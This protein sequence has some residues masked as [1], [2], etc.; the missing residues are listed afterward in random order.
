MASFLDKL[1]VKTAVT[2]RSKR[3]LSCCHITSADFFQFNV[4]YARELVP[5]ESIS[6]GLETF[7][8]MEPLVVP[9]FGRANIKNRAFFVPF[10]TVFPGWNDFI[11][12]SPHIAANASPNSNP[13]VLTSVPILSQY[14]FWNFL[15]FNQFTGSGRTTFANPVSSVPNSTQTLAQW[16]SLHPNGYDYIIQFANGTSDFLGSNGDYQKWK[17]FG[18]YPICL[19]SAGRQVMKLMNSLGYVFSPVISNT[20]TGI[21]GKPLFSALPLLCVAKVYADWFFPNGYS[22]SLF[23]NMFKYDLMDSS[24]ASSVLSLSSDYLRLIFD[25]ILRTSYDPDYFTSAWDQPNAPNASNL[26]GSYYLRD[27]NNTNG[28][29]STSNN[30]SNGTVGYPGGYG[31]TSPTVNST[32]YLSKYALDALAS[33]SDYI[34]RHQLVGARSIDR[35]LARFGIQLSSDKLDRSIYLGEDIV[36]LQIGDV[37]STADTALLGSEGTGMPLGSYAGKGIA[38]GGKTFEH[39]TDEYGMFII[40]SSIIPK[41]GYYQG[42]DR[43]VLHTSALSFWTPEFDSLGSQAISRAEVYEPIDN[44][45]DS[46]QKAFYDTTGSVPYYDTV[47][48]YTP[49]YAEYK[50]AHDRLTGDKRYNSLAVGQDSWHLM[51]V[52]NYR[53]SF[54]V[55]HS[56]NF[57]TGNLN[58]DDFEWSDDYLD[59]FQYDRI[60][61]NVDSGIDHFNIIYQFNVTSWAPM[62][63][64]YDNYEWKDHDKGETVHVDVNGPKMN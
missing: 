41:V 20:P 16:K 47:F 2:T 3:D 45:T 49:R 64:L 38:Y 37:M 8:R 54:D 6:V 53:S 33:L 40:V 22:T 27:I 34:K 1:K 15:L 44:L 18:G 57:V 59:Y 7:S 61:Q 60:F 11:T 35:F 9:T 30:A 26:S 50:V 17:S 19:T 39:S 55:V 43:S 23:D 14:N 58:P 42:F 24:S 10:R 48:G 51:R 13:F 46:S 12:Q 21:D 36:P 5:K 62:S 52:L 56:R 32:S 28:N 4:A 25:N 29:L 63:S 31:N